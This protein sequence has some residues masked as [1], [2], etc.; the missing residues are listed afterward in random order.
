MTDHKVSI[1]EPWFSL[2]WTEKKTVHIVPVSDEWKGAKKNDSVNF[3]NSTFGTRSLQARIFA[4]RQFPSVTACINQIDLDTAFPAVT[5]TE[6]C[7]SVA[8]QMAGVAST[9]P[10]IALTLK[11][12]K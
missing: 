12:V 6:Q 1:D 3:T 9:A 10:V 8:S 2:L 4:V 5:S 11:L 7:V